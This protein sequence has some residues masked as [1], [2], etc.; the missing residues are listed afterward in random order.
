MET[1]QTEKQTRPKG[2]V[3]TPARLMALV[4][5]GKYAIPR[6]VE[7]FDRVMMSVAAHKR[8]RVSIACPPRHGKTW[9][10]GVALPFYYLTTFPDRKV[11]Y[12]SHSEELAKLACE[13]V[14]DL[15]REFGPQL[16][17]HS[18][19]H[20]HAGSLDWRIVDGS[21]KST[22]GGM[23]GAGMSTGLHSRGCSLLIADDLFG[24]VKQ[25]LS[26]STR[27]QHARHFT[28]TVATRLTPDGAVVLIGTPLHRDDVHGRLQ[29][30]ED[31]GGDK[32]FRVKLPAIATQVDQLGRQPGEALWPEMWSRAY[33]DARRAAMIAEGQ[34]RDWRAQ[35]E[36]EPVSGDGATEWP[37]EYTSGDIWFE[38]YP[39]A[40]LVRRALAIDTSRGESEFGDWQAFVMVTLYR[41]G[42]VD[43]FF[44]EACL[45]R[46]DNPRLQAFAVELIR[47]W[48]PQAVI[49]ETNGIGWGLFCDLAV[50]PIDGWFANVLGREHSSKEE[51]YARIVTRLS[52]LLHRRALHFRRGQAGVAELV[53]QIQ[54]F[55]N[56]K[57]K[58]G[59]DALEMALEWI[60]QDVLPHGHPL[61]IVKYRRPRAA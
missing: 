47:Q 18:V 54:D 3:T 55:P 53:R 8:R 56:A 52:P 33:L 31:K 45:V 26:P 28:S 21:V 34:E 43:H 22:G 13:E 46:L 4:T 50:K 7:Y 5:G 58:D 29:E 49:V 41:L 38:D 12:L 2:K 42:V 30:A 32:W 39:Q 23:F 6:H 61:K 1:V 51:K 19:R 17:G 35:F 27:D 57:Y 36:L 44:I 20:S 40:P 16:T 48:R 59:P 15:Y 25:V 60:G 14:R 9:S 24:S 11:L 37:A 10:F